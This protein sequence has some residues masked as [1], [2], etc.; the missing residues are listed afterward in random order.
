MR[1]LTCLRTF[2]LLLMAGSLLAACSNSGGGNV[3]VA[4]STAVSGAV[5]KGPI[6]GATVDIYTMAANGTKGAFVIGGITTDA[7]GAWNANIP[8]GKTGPFLVIATGGSYVDEYT[9]ATIQMGGNS[10][11]GVMDKGATT[12]PISPVTDAAVATIRQMV[13]DGYAASASAA[14]PKVQASYTAS[15][16]F[17]PL[18][19]IPPAPSQL[20]TAT[21]NQKKYAALLGGISK[22]ANDAYTQLT[23][24]AAAPDPAT[25]VR[26]MAAD[27]GADGVINGVGPSGVNLS[28]SVGGVPKPLNAVFTGGNNVANAVTAFQASP[29][30]P[31][32]VAGAPMT[33]TPP[34]FNQMLFDVTAPVVTAPT[35]ITVAAAMGA[36]SVT[37]ADP[38]ITAFLA[39][40]TATDNV[41]VVGAITHNGPATFPL[42]VTIVTFTAKDAAGNSG[43]AT[44][45]VTVTATPDTILP[46]VT[47]PA[48]ITVATAAGATSVA[49]TNAT[50]A[51]F[52]VGATATDN[53]GVVG[54]ITNNAP[55]TFPVGVTTVTFTATDAAGNKGTATA[56]VTVTATPAGAGADTVKPVVTAPAN[57]SV[58][59][60]TGTTSV[61]VTDPYIAAFLT[62]ASATDNLG[63]VGAIT[64]DAPASFAVGITTVTFSAKDAAGNTGTAQATVTVNAAPAGGADT[65][66]PVVT[67]PA[68]I[69][70]IA[71]AQSKTISKFDGQLT[72]FRFGAT[73]ID[74]VDG[75]LAATD[76]MPNTLPIGQITVTF[77]ATDTAGNTGTATAIVTVAAGTPAPVLNLQLTNPTPAANDLYRIVGSGT[78]YVAVGNKGTAVSS[79]DGYT[80]SAGT[81][82]AN[83]ATQAIQDVAFGNG[84]YVAVTFFGNSIYSLDGYSWSTPS[85][86]AM[87]RYANG[88]TFG[89]GMFV[90]VGSAGIADPYAGIMTSVDG[91]T[92]TRQTSPT[93]NGLSDVIWTGTQFVAV[94]MNETILTSANG[95][96]WTSQ[97]TP[98][99]TDTLNAIA[100]NGTTLVAVGG[101]LPSALSAVL[102]TTDGGMTWIQQLTGIIQGTIYDVTWTGTQFVAVG[103]GDWTTGQ[104]IMTSPDGVTW[105]K[106]TSGQP[107]GAIL[108]GITADTTSGLMIA[109]GN[110]GDILTSTDGITWS[111]RKNDVAASTSLGDILW[112]GTQYVAVGSPNMSG[113]PA[114]ILTSLDGYAWT[115]QTSP[116]ATGG[117]AHLASNGTLL[118][119][120]GYELNI[121]QIAAVATSTD[122][123]TWTKQTITD[124]YAI[125][126]IIWSAGHN[127]FI[128]VGNYGYI[129]TS[130]DAVTWTRQVSGIS[131]YHIN[132]IASNGAMLVAIAPALTG[133]TTF[134]TSSD[135]ITWN[136]TTVTGNNGMQSI[137]WDGTQFMAAGNNA[138][139]MTSPD[140]LTWT[141]KQTMLTNFWI[142][143]VYWSGSSYIF[144]GLSANVATTVDLVNWS[145][146]VTPAFQLFG[147]VQ[148]PISGQVVIVGNSGN[149]GLILTGQ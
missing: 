97:T 22:L 100:S 90:A 126:D 76:N 77:S 20:G 83:L 9:G 7:Y 45:T 38:Y 149:S 113:T 41:G 72:A 42:G 78:G 14:L 54:A 13:I 58:T 23:A 65:I 128:A 27:L 67:P 66:P 119:A 48:S 96:T 80:W 130:P 148:N 137:I 139:V 110:G 34:N 16:G 127:M 122:G 4:T 31:P 102:T 46:V 73:A 75:V 17:D 118:V 61:P 21:A 81:V 59:A 2:L 143:N 55:A 26:L 120:A 123:I 10:F 87:P 30:A 141:M 47:A 124:P 146:V 24:G 132:G 37:V 136:Q 95:T 69:T 64:N 40:A 134:L 86:M 79:L 19:V 29:L 36:S 84:M 99:T 85:Y 108:R 6:N 131:T 107:F 106:Q 115:A 60:A 68:S 112:T 114:T 138:Q 94:G 142:S 12:A 63:V 82:P 25:L 135:G 133:G 121:S 144:V 103:T 51:A 52:L 35:N 32:A 8:A 105:T 49:K 1:I 57:I 62:G 125:N 43:T 109:V 145:Q 93:T 147:A 15:V 33:I 71:N 28:A 53:I 70:V 92:W 104:N 91:Y 98:A 88:I 129:S 89:N 39:G 11:Q 18:T 116:L 101:T 111:N 5:S 140:G 50:I 3:P 56:T 74:N 117:L 44:A